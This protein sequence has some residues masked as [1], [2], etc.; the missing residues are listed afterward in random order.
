MD[1]YYYYSVAGVIVNCIVLC[2][3]ST[4]HISTLLY[5]L[6]NTSEWKCTEGDVFAFIEMTAI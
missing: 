1:N 3:V 5:N 4:I 2:H 6:I